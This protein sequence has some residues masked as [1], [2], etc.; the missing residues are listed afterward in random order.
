MTDLIMLKLKMTDLL[1]LKLKFLH[2]FKNC[3]PVEL[4]ALE[5][6]YP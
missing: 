5:E 2:P 6:N 3:N 4:V 1:V